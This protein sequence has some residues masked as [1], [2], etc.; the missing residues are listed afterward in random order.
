[1]NVKSKLYFII[2][3]IGMANAY[4]QNIDRNTTAP[5]SNSYDS[6]NIS[7]TYIV[8]QPLSGF[9]G[10]S[11]GF[12]Q[13][14][15]QRINFNNIYGCTDESSCFFNPLANID[16]GSC[17]Y[18]EE[19]NLGNDI[20]TCDDSIVLDAGF[21]YD[22]YLWSNGDTTQTISV[23]E[24]GAY[25]VDVFNFNTTASN[26]SMSF[27]GVDDK[28]IIPPFFNASNDFTFSSWVKTNSIANCAGCSNPIINTF[29]HTILGLGV[30]PVWW[31]SENEFALLYGQGCGAG[32]WINDEY[33]ISSSIPVLSNWTNIT[34][35]KSNLQWKVYQNGE[36]IDS[37]SATQQPSSELASIYLG[38]S[39]HNGNTTEYLDGYLNNTQ[40]WDISLT[41]EEIISYMT[42]PPTGNESGLIGYWKFSE[43]S[44]DTVYDISG[45]GNHGVIYGASYSEDVPDTDCL[46]SSCSISDQIDVTFSPHG[47]TDSIAC[48][49]NL[50]AICEDG[51]CQYPENYYDCSGSCL[52]DSDNN[53]FCDEF[54][55]ST[56]TDSFASNFNDEASCTFYNTYPIED[57][58]FLNYLLENYPDCIVNDSLNLDALGGITNLNLD[59][60]NISSLDGIQYF[61]DLISLNCDNNNLI[62]IPTLPDGL[63]SLSCSGNQLTEISVLPSSLTSFSCDNNNLSVL[64]TLPDGLITA[65]CSGNQLTE[66]SVLP[67]SLTSFSCDNNNL[68][69][70]PTLPDGLTILSCSSN[71]LTEINTLP[72][73]LTSFSCDNNNLIVLPVLPVSLTSL[74]CSGNQ[75][76]EINILPTG[77]TSLICDGNNLADLPELPDNLTNLSCGGNDLEILVDLPDNLTSINIEDNP[78]IC[79]GSYPSNLNGDLSDYLPCQYGC[80]EVS[81]C[82]FNE[83]ALVTDSNCV[84]SLEFYNCSGVCENDTDGDGYCDQLEVYGCTDVIADNYDSLATENS[85]CLIDAG[86]SIE[87]ACNYSSYVV[88]NDLELCVFPPDFY[89]CVE[90]ISSSDGT[91]SYDFI[92]NN[93]TDG[94]GLCDEYEILGCIQTLAC[95]YNPDATQSDNSCVFSEPNYDCQGDCVNDADSDGVCDAF[96]ILG[97]TDTLYLEFDSNATDDNGFCQ[98]III[99]GCTNPIYIEFNEGANVDDESCETIAIEGCTDSLY[100]EYS[101]EFNFDNGSCLTLIV[102]GCMDS[103]YLEFNPGANLEDQS[104]QDLIIFGCTDTVSC[105]FDVEANTNN[106]LC[107]YPEIYFDCEGICLSDSDSDGVCDELEIYGCYDSTACNYQPLLTELEACEYLTVSLVE[108]VFFE[109]NQYFPVLIAYN[110]GLN[111]S[112]T[113]FEASE[114]ISSSNND[115]LFVEQNGDY[116]VQV[117]DQDLGCYGSDTIAVKDFNLNTLIKQSISIYPNPTYDKVNI[118]IPSGYTKIQIEL[119]DLTGT[120]LMSKITESKSITKVALSLA[121][122]VPQMCFVR[123]HMNDLSF[124]YPLVIQQK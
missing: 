86:C 34:V 58:G 51:T 95:N 108:E 76:T 31:P 66:I 79:V 93:D 22:A 15:L 80:M 2:L 36:L 94:D 110:D 18:I 43:G 3:I 40:I 114:E 102:E 30:D 14:L 63:I 42:C 27:D 87:T 91:I 53:G 46:I 12:N 72:T 52:N 29:P 24:S 101:Q 105:N 48:N 17:E 62:S 83:N 4:S 13:G 61:D 6:N 45:N 99:T 85:G 71:Q 112:Y 92:C 119:I 97:C 19:I 5:I 49:Y 68:T 28:I 1:M 8:G 35:S 67:S 121:E 37:F 90:V 23:E 123:I 7:L 122:L 73:G 98:T 107:L 124:T 120:I 117:Y 106:E 16:D 64:P 84:Y 78:I 115:T 70:L 104:C 82:N 96:E 109:D 77:L 9:V 10:E 74:S 25:S 60:L 47:C 89:Q 54:E 111:S 65:S 56:C 39:S 88:N 100:L 55:V 116:F 59:G 75:L 103:L 33:T 57:I 32:C 69:V 113:W 20:I 38:A 44:G 26:Y 118:E 11:S 21:G 41:Q 81:A 50:N